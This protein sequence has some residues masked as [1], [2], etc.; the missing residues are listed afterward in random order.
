[1][2]LL[3][4]YKNMG[5]ILIFQAKM[6]ATGVSSREY[7]FPTPLHGSEIVE[8]HSKN[9]LLLSQEQTILGIIFQ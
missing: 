4:I 3:G 7:C 5:Y 6:N 9:K 8:K 1:M 2:L